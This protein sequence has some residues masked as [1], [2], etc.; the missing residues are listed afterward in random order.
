MSNCCGNGHHHHHH[1]HDCDHHDCCHSEEKP[2]RKDPGEMPAIF[3]RSLEWNFTKEISGEQ[4]V[5][6]LSGWVEKLNQWTKEKSYHVGHIK[7]FITASSDLNLWLASTGREI[8]VKGAQK[9]QGQ[10]LQKFTMNLT[11]IIFGPR[12]EEL[13]EVILQGLNQVFDSYF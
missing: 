7:S 10:R 3:S 1:D 6:Q 2:R 9:W 11:A 5:Q 4:L 8:N 12:E 13:E